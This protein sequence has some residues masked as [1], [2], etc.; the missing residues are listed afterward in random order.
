MWQGANRKLRRVAS[1]DLGWLEVSVGGKGQIVGFGDCEFGSGRSGS[2]GVWQG[3]NRRPR[4]AASSGGWQGTNR[5]F[6]GLR[7]WIWEDWKFRCVARGNGRLRGVARLDLGW[8][9]VWVGG[10]GQIVGFGGCEFGSNGIGRFGAWQGA[11]R[12]LRGVAS[13]DLG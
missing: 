2:F 8:L 4:G 13:L 5:R 9:E 6:W 12:R 7:V 1:L 10:K 3:A 11:K